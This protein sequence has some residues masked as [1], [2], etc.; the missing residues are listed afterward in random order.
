MRGKEWLY[1]Q[2]KEISDEYEVNEEIR[3]I[4]DKEKI[5]QRDL[6]EILYDLRNEINNEG[7]EF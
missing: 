3:E 6:L 5:F 4:V 2:L 7:G 1:R